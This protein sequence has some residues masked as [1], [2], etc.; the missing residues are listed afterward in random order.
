MHPFFLN[1]V[2]KKY[3]SGN[4]SD[5]IPPSDSAATNYLDFASDYYGGIFSD[6]RAGGGDFCPISSTDIRSFFNSPM[7]G[8]EISK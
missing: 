7:R 3:T 5:I 8:K 1:K 4:I 2:I 6:N